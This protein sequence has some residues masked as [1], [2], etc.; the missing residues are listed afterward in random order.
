VEAAESLHVTQTTVS[1]R[2]KSLEEELRRRLFIRNRNGARLTASGS[3]FR[4]YA[5]S[6]LQVWERARHQVAVPTGKR[7]Y[8]AIGGEL[9]LWNPLV[10]NWMVRMRQTEKEIALRGSVGLPEQLM[11]HLRTGT[12]DI[13]VMYAPH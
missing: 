1:A 5:E 10:L 8:V 3:E 6:F 13:A 7:G 11:E 9:S 2:I 4:P 12:L